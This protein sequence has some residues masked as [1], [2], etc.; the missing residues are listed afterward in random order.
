MTANDPIFEAY[1]R[2]YRD[3]FSDGQAG[4]S[5]P[6]IGIHDQTLK[7]ISW[8][9]DWIP[10]RH[11]G[12]GALSATNPPCNE[13]SHFLTRKIKRG[14][15]FTTEI[16]RK[17]DL[18]QPKLNEAPVCGYCGSGINPASATFLDYT[19]AFD[20]DPLI[21]KSEYVAPAPVATD[22]IS[23]DMIAKLAAL[24]AQTIAGSKPKPLPGI[25]YRCGDPSHPGRGC[26]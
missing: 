20:L 19:D 9:S 3:G 16:L 17:R 26:Q 22:P 11:I 14:E 2:G 1:R 25:C 21:P 13:I 12:S 15:P 24:E 18:T 4:V 23:A 8:P 6:P 10:L 7:P 5:P